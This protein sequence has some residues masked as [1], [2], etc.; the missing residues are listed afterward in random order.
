MQESGSEYPLSH[1]LAVAAKAAL[2]RGD[3]VTYV[4]LAGASV[5]ADE[6]EWFE[7]AQKSR[8]RERERD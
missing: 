7:A 1:R 5:L 3:M 2:D 8:G 4:R 6:Q